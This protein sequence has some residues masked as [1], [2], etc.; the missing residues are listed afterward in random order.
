MLGIYVHLPIC[1]SKCHYCDFNSIP[2]IELIDDYISALL[3]SIP[4]LTEKF[5]L[6]GKKVDTI[7]FGGGTPSIFSN[8]HFLKILNTLHEKFEI[9]KE[10]EISIEVNPGSISKSKLLFYKD[11]GINRIS[12]GIQS[13][14]PETLKLIGRYHTKEDALKSLTMALKIFTNISADLMF[15]L[16]SQEITQYINDLQTLIKFNIPHISSYLLT[17][18]ENSRKIF[19]NLPPDEEIPLFFKTTKELLESYSVF[20]Y[21]SSNYA[22]Q[23][24]QCRHNLKYWKN[25]NYISFGAGAHS[26][27]SWKNKH[28]RFENEHNILKYINAI[29]NNKLTFS[30]YE[31]LS[32]NDRKID[33]IT[34]YLRLNSGFCLEEYTKLFHSNFM[35]DYAQAI[36]KNL[37]KEHIKISKNRVSLTENGRLFSNQVFL[38]FA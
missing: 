7:F 4:L 30:M 20:Q 14:N 3:K 13:F 28:V 22:K 27:I 33:F 11:T 38:D 35:Q 32:Q 29:K 12:I 8:K 5:H 16:P 10:A 19:K 9:K 34:S 31:D 15:G 25:K 37:K 1:K 6:I 21:E 17:L 2:K 23:N 26:F 36:E 18:N 24:S